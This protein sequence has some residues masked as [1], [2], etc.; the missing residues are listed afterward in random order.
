MN[1][2]LSTGA[3]MALAMVLAGCGG[4]DGGNQAAANSQAPIP[5]IAAPNNG[6]WT[7]IVSEFRRC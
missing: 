6:D 1:I 7:Q 5:Q 3:A 4:N 2:K